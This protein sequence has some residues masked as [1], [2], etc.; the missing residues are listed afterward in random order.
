MSIVDTTR[1]LSSPALRHRWTLA[2]SLISTF[3]NEFS[4]Q[5][6]CTT[7]QFSLSPISRLISMWIYRFLNRIENKIS[8]NKWGL[9][10]PSKYDYW[11]TKLIDCNI[12]PK[13]DT[14]CVYTDLPWHAEATEAR[15]ILHIYLEQKAVVNILVCLWARQTS[16]WIVR[17]TRVPV[18]T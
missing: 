13:S 15:S 11:L 9:K 8:E 10:K 1:G 16:C 3:L 5:T 6:V 12:T 17:Q 4:L 14:R 18:M 7:T 2:K